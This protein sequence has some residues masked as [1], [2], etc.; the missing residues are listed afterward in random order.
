MPVP[1]RIQALI[2]TLIDLGKGT[3]Q[4]QGVALMSLYS[5]GV[6]ATLTLSGGHWTWRTPSDDCTM[7]MSHSEVESF[8]GDYIGHI[9]GGA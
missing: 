9:G 2:Q 1:S 6:L 4:R 8:L 3:K 5:T 7:D